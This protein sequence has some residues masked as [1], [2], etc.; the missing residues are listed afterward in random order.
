M[1]QTQ[2]APSTSLPVYLAHE[3]AISNT[4]MEGLWISEIPIVFITPII[5]GPL[6]YFMYKALQGGLIFLSIKHVFSFFLNFFAL[7]RKK[8]PKTVS[9][10]KCFILKILH[11]IN[12]FW[13]LFSKKCKK[14]HPCGYTLYRI[15]SR[16]SS[17]L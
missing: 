5:V 16:P 10:Q 11:N 3:Q 13:A 4:P 9:A 6:D 7:F 8:C 2:D 12:Y 1:L 14:N 17:L 15:F